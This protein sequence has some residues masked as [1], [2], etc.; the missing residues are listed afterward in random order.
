MDVLDR[1]WDNLFGRCA[2]DGESW[3]SITT[4]YSL[5]GEVTG[6]RKFI[7]TFYPNSDR[8]VITH[9]NRYY[10][11][12]GSVREQSWQIDKEQCNQPNGLIHPAAGSMRAL[13]CGNGVRAW[14]TPKWQVGRTASPELFIPNGNRRNSLVIIYSAVGR[15]DRIFHI[16]EQLDEFPAPPSPPPDFDSSALW[17]VT[18]TQM[19]PDLHI[20]RETPTEPV[21]LDSIL[22]GD[23]GLMLTDGVAV[24]TPEKVTQGQAF[25]VVVGQA[26][27]QNHYERVK[28]KYDDSGNF[29]L[30][31]SEVFHTASS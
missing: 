10:E 8:S 3:H 30:L 9:T 25:D 24:Y 5:D 26:I 17:N 16:R 28:V 7:R 1:H 6:S 23:R 12:N 2:L 22:N 19:T 11:A 13:S 21:T 20:S 18:R 29:S 14:I 4:T 27:S 31:I 15:L